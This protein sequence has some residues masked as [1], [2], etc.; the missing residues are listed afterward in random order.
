M[1]QG[2][3]PRLKDDFQLEKF[4]ERKGVV[5]PMASLHDNCQAS[6]VGVNQIQDAL[7]SRTEDFCSCSVSGDANAIFDQFKQRL[8]LIAIAIAI[9]IDQATA[10]QNQNPLWTPLIL[11]F[12]VLLSPTVLQLD[13]PG[14]L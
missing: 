6:K 3:F 14:V 5:H 9:A 1:T 7:V 4:G 12:A 2:Q 11:V 10:N 13:L 8:Q